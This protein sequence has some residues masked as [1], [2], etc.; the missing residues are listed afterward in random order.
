L[1][2]ILIVSVERRKFQRVQLERVCSI[3]RKT[4]CS[5]PIKATT[6]NVSRSGALIR[7]DTNSEISWKIGE[8]LVIDLVMEAS[9]QYALKC[10]R[11]EARVVRLDLRDGNASFVAVEFNRVEFA[12]WKPDPASVSKPEPA[13][14]WTM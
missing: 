14:F 2:S 13:T 3:L 11:C 7:V 4:C 8:L 5:G 1:E 10:M 6:V 12:D 9:G